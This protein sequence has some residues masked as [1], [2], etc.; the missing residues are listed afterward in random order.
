LENSLKKYRK[1]QTKNWEKLIKPL[2][3]K[4]TQAVEGKE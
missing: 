2:K 4:K 3:K 1:T